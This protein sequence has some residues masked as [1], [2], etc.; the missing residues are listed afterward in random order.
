MH[1]CHSDVIACLCALQTRN[2]EH[3]LGRNK[4]NNEGY[5]KMG[6][7]KEATEQTHFL[8]AVLCQV[9]NN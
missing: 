4:K 6:C 9:I 3:H 1:Y 5:I 2:K 7:D 8:E